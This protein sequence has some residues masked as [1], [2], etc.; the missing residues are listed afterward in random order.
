MEGNFREVDFRFT[1]FYEVRL[2]EAS[3]YS[4][5]PNTTNATP[6][7]AAATSAAIDVAT[8]ANAILAGL[9]HLR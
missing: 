5:L 8:N 9:G 2:W 3:G 4:H 1:A 7:T 6:I